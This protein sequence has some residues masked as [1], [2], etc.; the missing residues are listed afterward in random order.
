[1]EFNTFRN[2]Q[3]ASLAIHNMVTCYQWNEATMPATKQTKNPTEK[4][5]DYRARLRAAG[6]RP[7]QIWVPDTRTPRLAEQARRQSLL[8]SAMA[9]EQEVSAFIDDV[10]DFGSRE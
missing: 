5:R 10:A 3:S 8:V 4:M 7:V 1:V 2:H 6:L 9:S